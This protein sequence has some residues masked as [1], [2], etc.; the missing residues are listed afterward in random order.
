[1]PRYFFHSR[2]PV[3]GQ[4]LIDRTGQQLP[5][6]ASARIIAVQAAQDLV[7]LNPLEA[8][9]GWVFDVVDGDGQIALIQPFTER[10]NRAG[11]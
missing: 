5:D 2:G 4:H 9:S 3:I 11:R 10:K 1:M 6:V 8:W 7:R